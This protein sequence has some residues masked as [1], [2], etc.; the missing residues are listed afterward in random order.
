MYYFGTDYKRRL[1]NVTVGRT[2]TAIILNDTSGFF[3]YFDLSRIFSTKG[4]DPYI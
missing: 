3:S 1:I 2:E 4:M